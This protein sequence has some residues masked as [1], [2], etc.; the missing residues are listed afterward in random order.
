LAWATTI[1]ATTIGVVVCACDALVANCITVKAVVASS[2]RRRCFM[3]IGIPK[4][5]A[6]AKECANSWWFGLG[7]TASH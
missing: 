6:A 5:L 3:M 1:W 7:S 4:V 2:T